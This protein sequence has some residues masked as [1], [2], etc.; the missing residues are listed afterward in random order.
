MMKSKSYP[1]LRFECLETRDLMAGDT[2]IPH[3]TDSAGTAGTISFDEESGVVLISGDSYHDKALVRNAGSGKIEVVATFGWGELDGI[4]W[5]VPVEFE[6]DSVTEIHFEG[7]SG[8]D[9]FTNETSIASKA[10]GGDGSDTLTGGAGK[11]RLYGQGGDDVLY[12]QGGEDTLWGGDGNDVLWGEA[13]DD[14]LYGHGGDDVLYGGQGRDELYGGVGDD[15]LFG[16]PRNDWL[17]GGDDVDDDRFLTQPGD[18]TAFLGVNDA[19]IKFN[20]T[21]LPYD[22]TDPTDLTGN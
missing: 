18:T 9:E 15:G 5:T 21:L 13:G 2:T 17:D 8:N 20:S 19:E 7:F 11:D 14:V 1:S 10:W 12:G 6:R 16:G 4:T 3:E 22:P